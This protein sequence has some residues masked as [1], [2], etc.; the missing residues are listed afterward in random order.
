M[1]HVRW[2]VGG[3]CGRGGGRVGGWKRAGVGRGS[4]EAGSAGAPFGGRLGGI[5]REQGQ[6]ADSEPEQQKGSTVIAQWAK[7]TEVGKVQGYLCI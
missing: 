4:G 5:E 7:G 3:V 1:R 2:W 6:P